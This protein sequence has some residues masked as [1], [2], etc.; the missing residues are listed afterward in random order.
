MSK[1]DPSKDKLDSK[2]YIEKSTL[3]AIAGITAFVII[4]YLGYDLL[5]GWIFKPIDL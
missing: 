5:I 4:F 2:K 1:H 3:V